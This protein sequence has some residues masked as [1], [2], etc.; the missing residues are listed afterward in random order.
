MVPPSEFV[1]IAEEAGT[2]SAIDK[3]A[4]YAVAS[5]LSEWHSR[6]GI[7]CSVNLSAAELNDEHLGNVVRGALD[8]ADLPP[9]ALR[10]E[11]TESRCMDNPE[12]AIRRIQEVR[13]L[14][15]EVW[16]DDFGTGQSSLSYLKRLP[17][18][19]IKIDKMFADDLADGA[20]EEQY[21]ENIVGS[22]HARGKQ[23]VVEGVT[24]AEQL[25]VL[26]RIG[27]SYAQGYYYGRPVPAEEL[28]SLL[29]AGRKLG[30]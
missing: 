9:A 11:L 19:V 13:D 28:E 29:A 30:G 14:G 16:V 20:Q 4:L 7:F 15:V 21:L 27:C 6:Y 17:V 24:A 23:V 10:L 8:S 26:R 12:V 5:Q 25:P 22:I 3:W 1:S 2:I 18:S